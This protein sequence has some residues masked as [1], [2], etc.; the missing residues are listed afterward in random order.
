MK[1]NSLDPFQPCTR[2]AIALAINSTEIPSLPPEIDAFSFFFDSAQVEQFA[3]EQ[4]RFS[5]ESIAPLIIIDNASDHAVKLATSWVIESRRHCEFWAH[6]HDLASLSD[7]MSKADTLAI[8]AFSIDTHWVCV[9]LAEPRI[10]SYPDTA[11]RMGLLAGKA[12]YTPALQTEV[13]AL[14]FSAAQMIISS[15]IPLVKPIKK[16]IPHNVVIILYKLLEKF[17]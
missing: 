11:L 3:R 16:Y 15:L 8:D 13:G 17:R 2:H 6:R 5:S 7:F 1:I 9:R 10:D 12:Q 14:K 4:S